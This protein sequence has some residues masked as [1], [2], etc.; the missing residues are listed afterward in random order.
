MKTNILSLLTL[1]IIIS[2]AS[3]SEKIENKDTTNA[4][5]ISLKKATVHTEPHKYGGWYC[6]DNLNGFPPINIANW[7]DVP[8]VNGRLATKEEIENGASLILIDT[9]K[10]P[11]AKPLDMTMPKLAKFDNHF[12]GREDLIIVIQ[13]VNIDNDPIVG[14]RYLNGGN[15]SARLSEVRILTD[16]EIEMMPAS[17]FVSH[18]INIDATQ[19]IIWQVLTKPESTKALQTTFDTNNSL[20]TN[21]RESSNVNFNYPNKGE[22]TSSFAD[23]LFGSFY[24]QN[25]YDNAQYTEKFLLLEDKET[26][27]TQLKI[28]SGPHGDDFADQKII[29]SNWAQKVKELSEVD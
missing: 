20:K 7:D 26:K 1:L 27:T 14:F 28:V 5:V 25:D 16:N 17:R 8:V 15:G 2:F 10:Y 29:V 24:V 3:C 13:A 11:N 22:I 9:D 19:D 6:P 23:K 21:W 12:T 4:E 18:N